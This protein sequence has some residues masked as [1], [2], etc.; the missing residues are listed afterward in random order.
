M[1]AEDLHHTSVIDRGIAMDEQ[2]PE[3][4]YPLS[5]YGGNM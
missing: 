2:I 5:A 3:M 4:G 1:T